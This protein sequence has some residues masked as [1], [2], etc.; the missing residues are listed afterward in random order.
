[1][2]LVDRARVGVAV[3]WYG[4][5]LERYD[6]SRRARRDLKRELRANLVDAASDGR[7]ARAAVVSLGGLRPLARAHA[8]AAGRDE[9]PHWTSAALLAIVV[10]GVVFLVQLFA[11]FNFLAGVDAVD[12]RTV[13]RGSLVPFPG[14]TIERR[15]LD[16]GFTV[17]IDFGPTFAIV[18]LAVF[19]L[20]ARPWRLLRRGGVGA[21]VL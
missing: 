21:P 13:A 6:V 18:A 9:R 8:E 10:A 20:A 17:S 19:V 7:G 12:G 16:A 11:A 15:P 2:H 3:G 1:M 5:W 4:L 14:S